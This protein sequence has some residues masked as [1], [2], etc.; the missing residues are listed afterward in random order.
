MI[1]VSFNKTLIKTF[2]SYKSIV[3]KI[4]HECLFIDFI[5]FFIGNNQFILIFS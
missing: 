4:R 1:N 3:F 5:D 2:F